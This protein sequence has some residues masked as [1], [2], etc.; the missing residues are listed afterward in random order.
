[1]ATVVENPGSTTRPADVQSGDKTR[2]GI[3]FPFRKEAGELPKRAFDADAVKNDLLT[4]FETPIRSRV[5]RPTF[6]STKERLVFESKGPLLNARLQRNIRQTIFLHEP[7]VRIRQMQ[8]RESK[9]E[10]I[11]LI[12][13][14][15]QGIKDSIRLTIDRPDV[16]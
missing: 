11:A 12:I 1:M 16:A 7:R 5:M 8:V 15:V 3:A 14:T 6:G 10:V 13:Y 9:T 4:L 2:I